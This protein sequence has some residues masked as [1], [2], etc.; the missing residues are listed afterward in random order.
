M[1]ELQAILGQAYKDVGAYQADIIYLY[2]DFRHFGHYVSVF[3]NRDSFCNVFAL[4]FL[5]RD[6]TVV[7]TTFTYTTEGRFDVL[8]TPTTSGAMNKWILAQPGF[9]RSEH[10]LFSYAALGPQAHLIEN[11]GKSAFGRDSVHDRLRGRRTA[12]LHIGHPVATG[13]TAIHHIEH[14][15]GATYRIH[16]AFRTEV[17]RGEQYIGT[18][19]TAF[20]R[21]RD[22]SNETFEFDFSR[23]ATILFEKGLITQ[24]GSDEHL[25]N[26]SFYWYD[27]T[28]ECLADSFYKDPNLFIRSDFRQY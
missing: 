17:Y 23:A 19:Y 16:K 28:L 11:I 2:T 22:V 5:E 18:D 4:P 1:I 15:C 20:V 13:N 21:R 24:V 3:E 26:V 7:L 14:V 27:D 8:K 25:S 12:F 6:K 10:P 9:R